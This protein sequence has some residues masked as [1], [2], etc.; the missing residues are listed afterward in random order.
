MYTIAK[1]TLVEAISP[2]WSQEETHR[3]SKKQENK[4]FLEI[5]SKKDVRSTFISTEIPTEHIVS[6]VENSYRAHC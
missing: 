2:L 5:P 1:K 4:S 3:S 6:K